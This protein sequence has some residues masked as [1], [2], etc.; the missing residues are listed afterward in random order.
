MLCLSVVTSC[1][2]KKMPGKSHKWQ[3]S[4]YNF[5]GIQEVTV[6]EQ[7]ALLRQS[8]YDG[9]ILRVA[10]PANFQMLPDFLA[11][12]D[13]YEDFQIH[14]VFV[15]YNFEDTVMRERWIEVM[16]Q[17]ANKRIQLWVIFGKKM[18]G[19][20]EIFIENKLLEI[21]V[22]ALERGVEVILYP[23]SSTYYESVDEALPMVKQINSPNLKTAV[24]LY[25]EIRAGNGH[26]IH[27]VLQN[28]SGKLGAVTLA[29]ADS[30]ADF[31]SPLAR[32]TSTIKPLGRGT[33][34]VK[35]FVKALHQLEYRGV[36][37]VMNFSIRED[38]GDYLP[39]SREILNAYMPKD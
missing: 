35:G 33:F 25:H 10:T 7:V 21:N 31:S 1:V 15:R 5:G 29:G 8:G 3:I 36:I 11:E 37:G 26:R 2:E 28:S 24:H 13:K 14:A 19:Y 4:S 12:A 20:D 39:R 23:H 16:D 30:V 32:D 6:E 22:Y 17:I 34:D 18:E 27:E 38:P 9:L